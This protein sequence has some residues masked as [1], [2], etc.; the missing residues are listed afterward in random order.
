MEIKNASCYVRL[1]YPTGGGSPAIYALQLLLLG[2]NSPNAVSA[3]TMVPSLPAYPGNEVVFSA[4]ET[5]S[6][7]ASPQQRFQAYVEVREAAFSQFAC[8][9]SGDLVK[10]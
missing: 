10:L 4:S 8:H 7:F 1:K 3:V 2:Q 5:L 9:I 6:S